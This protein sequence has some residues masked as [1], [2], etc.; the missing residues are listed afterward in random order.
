MVTITPCIIELNVD[1]RHRCDVY[2]NNKIK[3]NEHKGHTSE[4]IAIH[5][6][7]LYR[8]DKKGTFFGY[9]TP[10]EIIEAYGTYQVIYN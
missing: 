8:N 5:F 4:G 9:Y 6:F 2:D 7:S 1:S 3:A 10:Y